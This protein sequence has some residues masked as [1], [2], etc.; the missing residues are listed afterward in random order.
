MREPGNP[1]RLAH[2]KLWKTKAGKRFFSESSLR[3][4]VPIDQLACK[5]QI[6]VGPFRVD[7]NLILTL[8]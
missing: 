5:Q 7:R 4:Y 3:L 6:L 2:E 8:K 1:I